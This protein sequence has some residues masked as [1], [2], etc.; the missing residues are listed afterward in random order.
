MRYGGDSYFF[1]LLRLLPQWLIDPLGR[2]MARTAAKF[3]RGELKP[4]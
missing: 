2:F 3:L 4:K 1:S